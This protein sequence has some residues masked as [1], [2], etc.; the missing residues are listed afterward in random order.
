[1]WDKE[2]AIAHLNSHAHSHSLGRCA[3]YVRKAIEAGGLQLF[4]HG[5]AKDYGASLKAV[6]FLELT[7]AQV[8]VAGD[9]IVIQPIPRHPHGHITMFN[10]QIWV[11]DFKQFHGFYP[12]PDYRKLEPSFFLYRY[13]AK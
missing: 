3:E 10:G 5:S 11:S 7:G 13:P 9:V 2:T 1:M 6:R 8:P 12:G 4:H